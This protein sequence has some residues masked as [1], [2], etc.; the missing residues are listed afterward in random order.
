MRKMS[1]ECVLMQEGKVIADASRRL[2][3]YEHNYPTYDLELAA[4]VFTL[5]IWRRNLYDPKCEIFTNYQSL[6]SVNF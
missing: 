6:E 4:L 2:K 1:L 3:P 5:K